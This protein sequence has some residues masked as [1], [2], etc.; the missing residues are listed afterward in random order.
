MQKLFSRALDDVINLREEM[1]KDFIY[2][3]K[4]VA[5][6]KKKLKSL[7]EAN[8]DLKKKVLELEQMR[9]NGWAYA[10]CI[11]CFFFIWVIWVRR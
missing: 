4:K 11:E 6:N 1:F 2:T 8:A 3:S 10:Y 9:I 7:E 5:E